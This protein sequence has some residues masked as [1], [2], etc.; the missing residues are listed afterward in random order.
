MGSKFIEKHKRKSILG[1]LLLLFRGRSKYIALL[2]IVIL[3]SLPFVAT[4]DMIER[5]F[6][7]SPVRYLVKL[8]GLESVIASINPK[9]ST[10]IIKAT[11]DRLK[12]ETQD[13]N[14]W[15]K[16]GLGE[17]I[18]ERGEDFNLLKLMMKYLIKRKVKLKKEKEMLML[19]IVE[20]RKGEKE[21]E[22]LTLM[23]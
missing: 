2:V 13:Y 11:F 22:R 19:G 20:I 5:F 3:F 9:Y 18:E 7:I 23:I 4:S 8:F 17:E 16:I 21:I 14:L 10:D 6:G 12:Q 1:L 15:N